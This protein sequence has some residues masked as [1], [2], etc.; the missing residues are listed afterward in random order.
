M[1]FRSDQAIL[2]QLAALGLVPDDVP[3]WQSQRK[4]LYLRAL[5]TL[6]ERGLVYPC[7]C[8][9][10]SIAARLSASA[11]A[12]P[13]AAGTRPSDG[14]LAYPGTCRL[15]LNGR[16]ARAW[17]FDTRQPVVADSLITWTDRRLG[18][19]QQNVTQSVGDF[20]L[21]RADGLWAYQLAV[22]VDDAEQGITHVVRGEDLADN[23][24]RQMLLQRALGLPTPHY[25]HTPLVHAADGRKLSKQNGAT[26]VA[27]QSPEAALKT[28]VD[29]GA[30]LGLAPQN[31]ATVAQWLDQ[32]ARQ[33]SAQ[34]TTMPAAKR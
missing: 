17:R 15:G 29:A 26:A 5:D 6:R 33:W 23:T 18:E 31:A 10:Q 9:R 16:A 7:C 32:A 3:Q 24:P 28:L 27:T 20:V 14:E 1:L 13:A 12:T 11:T 30:V 19:Q 4:L 22:V 2:R 21:H 25:L 34:W 8:T